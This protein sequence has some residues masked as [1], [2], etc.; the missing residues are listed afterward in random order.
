M[1][2]AMR[3][4]LVPVAELAVKPAPK[5][6]IPMRHSFGARWPN[7]RGGRTA[8]EP[9]TMPRNVRRSIAESRCPREDTGPDPAGATTRC[10]RGR[11]CGLHRQ[12]THAWHAL[13]LAAYV[14]FRNTWTTG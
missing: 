7:A 14:R 12:G 13:P 2:T 5:E 11:L 10:E 8:R 1:S 3:G 4:S 9:N 6:R